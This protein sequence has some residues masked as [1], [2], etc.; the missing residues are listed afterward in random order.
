[1]KDNLPAL[2]WLGFSMVVSAPLAEEVFFRGVLFQG[3]NSSLPIWLSLAASAVAFGAWHS[4][5]MPG[6]LCTGLFGLVIALFYHRSG[7]LWTAILAH[8]FFNIVGFVM[9]LIGIYARG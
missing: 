9:L 4:Y 3:L 8:S 1:M 2:V 5:A 6:K 7:S